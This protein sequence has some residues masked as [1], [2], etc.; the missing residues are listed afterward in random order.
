MLFKEPRLLFRM[1]ATRRAEQLGLCD[2]KRLADQSQRFRKK[3]G[4]KSEEAAHCL[5]FCADHPGHKFAYLEE[6][7]NYRVPLTSIPKGRLCRIKE[8]GLNLMDPSERNLENR[9]RYAKTALML[10]YPLRSLD[11]I[12]IDGTYWKKFDSI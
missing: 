4:K 10:F 2:K 5:K 3:Q 12:Q 8:L 1:V 11:D 9:E 7:K 6:V